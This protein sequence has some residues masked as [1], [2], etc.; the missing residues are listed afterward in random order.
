MFRELHNQEKIAK[1]QL[2]F[3][4]GK[5][6][7]LTNLMTGEKSKA[8]VDADGKLECTMDKAADYRMLR[9]EVK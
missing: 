8:Q 1:V 5:K 6:L 2:K 9:Y 4:A 7:A 3:L